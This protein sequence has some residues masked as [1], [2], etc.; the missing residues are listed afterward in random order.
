MTMA[1]GAALRIHY[2]ISL[3]DQ[4]HVN[5]N[6]T[7]QDVVQPA[8]QAVQVAA[9]QVAAPATESA[10]T[11]VP[12]QA[13]P[14][15]LF[16]GEVFLDALVDAGGKLADVRVV[17][18]DQ[19]FLD[20]VLEAI[21]TW[22]FEPARVD[23]RAVEAR[24]GIAFQFPQSFLPGITPRARVYK[25]ALVDAGERG[26]LPIA[27]IEP[28]YPINSIAEGSVALY[29]TVDA[30]GQ[31]T[32]T[33]VVRDVAS[34]TVPTEAAV[35]QWKFAPGKQAGAKADSAVVVVVTFRRPTQ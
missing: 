28:D 26:A 6:G 25:E 1:P 13:Q 8:A 35:Q 32:E 12:A 23:G 7:E 9:L 27:T 5:W 10:P 2:A 33:S 15:A 24:I 4:L 19:P 20:V 21:H 17:N 11:S 22:S 30:Q 3:L 16:G 14:Q 18:G 29:A 31:I 34:L